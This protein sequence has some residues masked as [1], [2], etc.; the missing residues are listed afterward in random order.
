MLPP[1]GGCSVTGLSLCTPGAQHR[2]AGHGEQRLWG[3][4][5]V[6]GAGGA[7]GTER[8]GA[9]SALGVRLSRA[10]WEGDIGAQEPGCRS[11]GRQRRARTE[12]RAARAGLGPHAASA[13]AVRDL[14][15]RRSLSQRLHGGKGEMRATPARGVA[16]C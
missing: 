8:G 1:T 11:D 5:R 10:T 7:E 4:G 6:S 14:C 2:C 16:F 15:A 12:G 13:A 9:C 3:P